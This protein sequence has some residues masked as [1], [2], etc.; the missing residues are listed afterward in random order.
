MLVV[1]EQDSRPE[2]IRIHRISAGCSASLELLA[3][4][5]APLLAFGAAGWQGVEE[6]I[7]VAAQ[8]LGDRGRGP[9][10]LPAIADQL[11]DEGALVL[12]CCGQ[13][14]LEAAFGFYVQPDR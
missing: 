4:Q 5:P 13:K 11:A 2:S 1:A 14:L 8:L 3:E 7:G 9:A 12:A 6:V 10:L